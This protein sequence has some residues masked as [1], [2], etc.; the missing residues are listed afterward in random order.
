[1]D[2]DE[3]CTEEGDE[4]VSVCAVRIVYCKMPLTFAIS[5]IYS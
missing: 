5:G 4:S 1:M 3:P 2:D